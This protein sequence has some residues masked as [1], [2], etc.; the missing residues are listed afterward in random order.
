MTCRST[1]PLIIQ[2][3]IAVPI[4]CGTDTTATASLPSIHS[5]NVGVRMLP[6]PKPVTDAIAPATIA[7]REIAMVSPLITDAHA[8][9]VISE[10]QNGSIHGA[11]GGGT[12]FD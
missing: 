2:N 11:R 4:R 6:M 1:C 10:K 9:I 8:T 12:A 5:D 7:A 3:R